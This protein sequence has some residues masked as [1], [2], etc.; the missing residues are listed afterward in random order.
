MVHIQD[1]HFIRQGVAIGTLT[2]A[3]E[4]WFAPV[5]IEKP[6]RHRALLLLHGFGSTPAVYRALLPTLTAQYDAVICPVLTGHCENLDAF[7]CSTAA[8]WLETAETALQP[9][10]KDYQK[11]D[12]LG[13]SLGGLIACELSQKYPLHHLYLLAPALALKQLYIRPTLLAARLLQCIGIKKIMNY[14]GNLHTDQH[15]ELLYRQL[16]LTTIQEML[17]FVQR[18]SWTPPPCPTDLFLGY[19]D[20]V[21]DS[22]KIARHFAKQSTISIHWLMRSAHVLPLDGDIDYLLD[23]IG[24][25]RAV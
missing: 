10:L 25:D 11:V 16:P 12:V 9:L 2:T 17:R 7:A 19:F 5:H 8:Q 18:Y 24:R 13:L 21:V 20:A 3:D 4:H 6:G 23:T 22:A 14:G 15:A 1:F